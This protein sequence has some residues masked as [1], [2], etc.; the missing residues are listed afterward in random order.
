[1][2]IM[3]TRRL[4]LAPL[5]FLL[6]CGPESRFLPSA[7]S[8]TALQTAAGEGAPRATVRAFLVGYPRE[9]EETRIV[10]LPEG[11]DYRA[12]LLDALGIPPEPW[13]PRI[14]LGMDLRMIPWFEEKVLE[15]RP[16]APGRPGS[17]VVQDWM[18]AITEIE[19]D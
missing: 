3:F 8:I 2:C 19:E 15:H 18:G 5:A 17:Y 12:A 10:G 13:Q 7:P 16:A 9:G 11:V 4:L 6:A 14:D 1:M